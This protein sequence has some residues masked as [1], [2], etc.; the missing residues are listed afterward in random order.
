MTAKK[1]LRKALTE[2][3]TGA[4]ST[5]KAHQPS[6]GFPIVALGASAGGLGAFELFFREVRADTG[7][8]FVLVQHLDPDHSSIL[9]QILQRSTTMPV[10]EAED[11]MEVAPNGV[12]VIPPNRDMT[13]L[14]GALQLNVPEQPRGHRMPIDTFLRSLAEDQGANAIGI[15]LS[16]T[17]ADGTL[18]LRA[19]LDA[20]G[21][22]LVQEPVTAIY[23]GMPGSAIRAGCATQVLPVEKMPAALLNDLRNLTRH[24]AAPPEP[25]ALPNLIP[26]L[27][28]LRAGSGH[29]F[30]L[31]KKSTVGRR[32]ARRMSQHNIDDTEVYAHYLRAH[33]LE[34]QLL[35]K[36]LLIN[37]T[38]FFRDPEA[39]VTLKHDIL[40][41]LLA[42]KPE[43]EVFRGWVAG[44][45][46]GEEA[47]SIA[48]VLRELMNETQREFKVKLYSTD[49]DDEAI[50]VARAGIY[51]P[52]IT[53]HVTPERLNRFFIKEDAGYRVKKEIREMVVFASQ[54]VTQD[55]PFIKLDLLSCRNLMIYL[56][57]ALQ[58]RLIPTFHYALKPRGVLFLSPSESIANHLDLF[59]PLSRRWKIYRTTRFATDSRAAISRSLSWTSAS[60]N[61]ASEEV[62][63]QSKEINFVE[64][65]KRLL[66]ESAPASVVTDMQGNIL[67]VHG[68]TG[69]YLRP[70]P[71]PATLNIVEMAR[72]GLQ[73]ELRAAMQ[74]GCTGAPT[75]SRDVALKA[76]GAPLLVRLSVR[77]LSDA[78]SDAGYLLVSFQD[79]A[80]EID[81]LTQA[82]A[83]DGPSEPRSIEELERELV[84]TKQNLQA[85]IDEQQAANEELQSNNEEMQSTTEELQ[86]TNEELETSKEELQSLNEE[87][88]TVNTEF[89]AKIEQLNDIQNDMKNLFDNISVGT[90]FLDE[91]LAIRRFTREAARVY[92]LVATDVGRPLLDIKCDLE[93]E[94][95]LVEAQ[96]VLDTLQPFEHQARTANGV[97]YLARI[98]PYRTLDNTIEGVVLT[99][100]DV[101]KLVAAEA[102]ARDARELAEAVVDTVRAPLIVLDESL[103]VVSASRPFYRFFQVLPIDTVGRH[104]YTLGDGQWDIPGLRDLLEK[105]LP[106]NASF[107]DVEV[108]GEFPGIGHRKM[109]LSGKRILG[110]SGE[111]PLIL[112]TIKNKNTGG[113]ESADASQDASAPRLSP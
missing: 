88:V 37:V 60:D 5:P 36:E 112:L 26:I 102:A 38:S 55:P 39:F 107:D 90:I 82:T 50:T 47:Y 8:A 108:D 71:G 2:T 113:D 72:E 103:K 63:K 83:T 19:I 9:G 67:Y 18:G 25:V 12:Y 58:N 6:A 43:D 4:A 40:P 32:I 16:G 34:I 111:K 31:Y 46:T 78:Q 104:L 68:D 81:G 23:D 42:N 51:P 74:A 15:I 94:D 87:L 85:I 59:V 110:T 70:A 93:D 54:N 89:Q 109:H 24:R 86:S 76:D 52:S 97:W 49:L 57:A 92:R 7:M 27:M 79:V 10:V 62:M 28:L 66:L 64:F 84:D 22:S 14:H 33:P 21:V 41:K 91:H 13:I 61:D 65:I 77:P 95:L 56:E 100:T 96:A 101:S 73:P 29:D 30:S 80:H 11:R 75:S 45:A 99:F 69:K 20:G 48:I 105:V 98:Q 1:V 53:Q 35:F 17:G 106:S 44:C 3:Q